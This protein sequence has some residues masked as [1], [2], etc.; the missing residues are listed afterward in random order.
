M[1]RYLIILSSFISQGS[2]LSQY[3]KIGDTLSVVAVNDLTLR[4]NPGI[5]ENKIS[6]LKRGEKIVILKTNKIII[7]SIYGF[8]G[9]WIRV[10]SLSNKFEGYVFDAFISRYP[11]LDDL[12]YLKSHANVEYYDDYSGSMNILAG[13]VLSYLDKI[14]C[15]MVYSNGLDGNGGHTM[16]MSKLNNGDM[17]IKHSFWE[18]GAIELEMV[19]P[20]NSEVYYL[21][22]DLIKHN[23]NREY[24]LDD[25]GLRN[26]K[27][28]ISGE[29][30]CVLET[31]YQCII[32][33]KR[34][35]ESKISIFYYWGY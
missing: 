29:S 30:S 27:Y 7:D 10:L 4:E 33:V 12:N 22:L 18:G 28:D 32:D 34:K 5:G 1:Y 24:K 31:E 25:N 6:I 2:L 13:Y 21:V 9:N 8:K 17:L 14:G 3:Y 23:P 11:V 16:F 15:D 20:R 35:D 19:N 26:P